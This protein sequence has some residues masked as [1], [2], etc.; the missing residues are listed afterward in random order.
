M[1]IIDSTIISCKSKI[2]KFKVI[3]LD[4]YGLPEEIEVNIT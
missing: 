3:I 4:N 1:A 2:E